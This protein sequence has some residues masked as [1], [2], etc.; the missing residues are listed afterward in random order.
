MRPRIVA[1]ATL[2]AVAVLGACSSGDSTSLPRTPAATTMTLDA[3]GFA[4]ANFSAKKTAEEFNAEDLVAMFGAGK[5]VCT[6]GTEPCVP[7]PEAAAFARMVNQAR[8]S[9]HCEGLV[10]LA[11]S[12]FVEKVSP[13]TGKLDKDTD[14]VHAILRAFATQFLPESQDETDKWAKQ[15]IDSILAEVAS[16]LG[17]D[18]PEYTLNLYTER[19]G[20]AMLPLAIEFPDNDHAVLHVYDS[21]WPDKDRFVTFDLKKK[22]WSFSFS[23]KDPS[24]DPNIWTGGKGDID[25]ASLTTRKTSSCPFCG[26]KNNVR[27]T[28]L[29]IRSVDQ[30]IEVQTAEGTVTPANPVAGEMTLRPLAGPGAEPEP[31]QPRDYIVTVPAASS[32][33]KVKAGSEARIIAVTPD[34]IAEVSTPAGGSPAPIEFNLNWISVDDPDVQI[35][36]AAGDYVATSSGSNNS[37]TVDENG[38]TVT[39]DGAGGNPVTVGTSGDAPAIEVDG[40]GSPGLP[41]DADYVVKSQSLGGTVEQT[42]VNTDGTKETTPVEGTLDSTST[43]PNLSDPLAATQEVPGLPPEAERSQTVDPVTTTSTT[44]VVGTTVEDDTSGS[45]TKTTVKPKT[46]ATTTAPKTTSRTSVTVSMN[47]DEWGFGPSDPASSG[48]S[49]SLEVSGGSSDSCSSAACLE[50]MVVEGASTGTDPTTGRT[51]TTTATFVMRSVASPFSAR[52][53]TTG[54]WQSATASGGVYGLT[55]T[56]SSVTKDETVYLRT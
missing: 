25:I 49:A 34:A 9:G 50:G 5:D 20:H 43:S 29:V 37:I 33:P 1:A 39:V 41:E 6:G 44:T 16:N 28:M 48:F 19:G 52:C 30:K 51:I 40:A 17:K 22:E 21:N 35:T 13:S 55:C 36:L 24:N 23:G 32:A 10:A 53:G 3:N 14:V 15:S 8:A 18:V 54:S 42:V 56:I 45:T 26:D 2:V 38:V 7:T 12:R 31:G 4:F 11:A 46:T 27:N 47:L